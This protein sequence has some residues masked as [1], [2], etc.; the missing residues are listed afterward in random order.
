MLERNTI[1]HFTLTKCLSSHPHVDHNPLHD[2]S[3]AK[4]DGKEPVHAETT[5]ARDKAQNT[6]YV[7]TPIKH[8]GY[9]TYINRVSI[10]SP[11]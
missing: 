5:F 7:F 10:N 4:K 3:N 11:W 9:Q 2:T 8:P 6:A 1:C